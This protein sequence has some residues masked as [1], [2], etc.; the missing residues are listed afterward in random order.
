MTNVIKFNKEVK[1]VEQREV[2]GKDFKMYGTVEE[3]LLITKDGRVFRINKH[4]KYYKNGNDG[5]VVELPYFDWGGYLIVN[6]KGKTHKV[7]RLVAE[8]F[9]ENPNNYEQVNHKDG[10][11]KN[12]LADNL[13]WC[14]QQQNTQHAY[15]NG[16]AFSKGNSMPKDKNPMY[17]KRHSEETKKLMSK[18]R[19]GYTA[20]NKK[21]TKHYASN[22]ATLS[23]FKRVCEREGYSVEDFERVLHSRGKNNKYL[24]IK[25]EV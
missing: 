22:P 10:N 7:H 11:K 17:G 12:N 20:H 13:E 25:R 5:E 3:P 8:C 4:T 16:L 21:D 2:L 14:T 24:F 6:Y 1:V 9:V 18:N 15:D 19:K 23:T